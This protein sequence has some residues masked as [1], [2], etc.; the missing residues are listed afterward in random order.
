MPLRPDP[1]SV[2][3]LI[4]TR[5]VCC[6]CAPP[7]CDF[8]MTAMELDHMDLQT[9]VLQTQFSSSNDT[10]NN[11]WDE[12]WD[13]ENSSARLFERSRIKALAA[14]GSAEET[15]TKWVN[16]HLSRNVDKALQF[17]KEQ[18]VHLENM[19]CHDIIQ[20]IIVD[21]DDNKEK[22]SAK[23]ALLLWCQMKTAGIQTSTSATSA[24]AGGTAWPSTHSSTNTDISVDQPDDKSVITYG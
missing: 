8:M 10:V 23:D 13:N 11:R 14:R 15:F 18:R 16:S 9:S 1:L 17:L 2:C 3:G 6:R 12:E 7:P 5:C 22:R 19:G 20:D 4:C 24:P 21:C